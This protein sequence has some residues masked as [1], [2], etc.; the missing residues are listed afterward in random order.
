M[1]FITTQDFFQSNIKLQSEQ[2]LAAAN[3]AKNLDC[4]KYS[5]QVQA[6]KLNGF[7]LLKP[8]LISGVFYSPRENTCLY[9]SYD[10]MDDQFNVVNFVT[11]QSIFNESLQDLKPNQVGDGIGM[12]ISRYQ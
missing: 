8:S 4:Q 3:F 9:V 5:S 7:L 1:F 11:E 6:D 10:T 2:N 12:L